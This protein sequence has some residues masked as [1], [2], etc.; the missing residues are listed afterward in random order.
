MTLGDFGYLFVDRDRLEVSWT[1][2][3]GVAGKIV[4]YELRLTHDDDGAQWS[5]EYFTTNATDATTFVWTG[6]TCNDKYRAKARAVMA[7]DAVYGPNHGP[8][9]ALHNE[10]YGEWEAAPWQRLLS[11]YVASSVG[12]YNG[13]TLTRGNFAH[14]NTLRLDW[15]APTDDTNLDYYEIRYRISGSTDDDDESSWDYTKARKNALSKVLYKD[16]HGTMCGELYEVQI[17][18]SGGKGDFAKGAWVTATLRTRWCPPPT[19]E[20]T[21]GP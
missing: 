21:Q 16:Q 1:P 13:L 18:P 6:L 12:G 19:K 15:I 20:P 2:A 4:R 17:R 3:A 9:D 7:A 11:C 14:R 10:V 8:F 5:T